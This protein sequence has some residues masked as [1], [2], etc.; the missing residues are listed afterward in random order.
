M[1]QV[2]H[3]VGR[4]IPAPSRSIP[5]TVDPDPIAQFGRWY[6]DAVAA[7][8]RQPDAM[9]LATVGARRRG[10]TARTVLLRGLDERGFAFYTNLES[11]KAEQLAA[12]PRPRSCST[13]ASIERQVR[14]HGT[15]SRGS[16]TTTPT[17]YWATR[18]RGH[19]LS[20]WASP[21]SEVVD[22]AALANGSRRWRRGFATT[23][24]RCRRSGAVTWST[25]TS[26][27][28][29][30]GART[31]CTTAC[32]TAGRRRLGPANGSHRERDGWRRAGRHDRVRTRRLV[33]QGTRRSPP[34]IPVQ[35]R[36]ARRADR[37]R[38]RARSRDRRRRPPCVVR[39][40]T[41]VLACRRRVP[42]GAA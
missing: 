4:W 11:A 13:G 12:D 41:R 30:R 2:C 20:A 39:R 1:P 9:T 17:Q 24:C 15:R 31:G 3:V 32:A 25:S 8:V 34:R 19:R 26:S 29:G 35:T 28:C 10:P 36:D 16:R 18:P 7:G 5:N 40:G 22:A 6:D 27:S 42:H 14:V 37:R 38:G 21:Q 33:E 23:T